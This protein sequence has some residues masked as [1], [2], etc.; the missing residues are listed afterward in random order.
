MH[1]QAQISEAA[2][3]AL[4]EFL[5]HNPH[6]I[7]AMFELANQ[8]LKSGQLDQSQREFLQITQLQPNNV[9]A[10]I[11]LGVVRIRQKKPAFAIA[12]FQQACKIDPTLPL[13]HRYLGMALMEHR[14][15]GDAIA[16]LQTAA[17]LEAGN[18]D[19]HMALGSA[20]YELGSF[21]DAAQAYACAIRKSPGHELAWINLGTCWALQHKF[22]KAEACFRIAIRVNSN[23]ETGH[24]LLGIAL[25]NLDQLE[26]AEIHLRRAIHLHPANPHAYIALAAVHEKRREY[27][28]A[29]LCFRQA[30][31]MDPSNAY[32]KFNLGTLHLR[33]GDWTRGF[34]LYEHRLELPGPNSWKPASPPWKGECLKGKTILVL[35]EQGIGDCLQF[36]RFATALRD[37]GATVIMSCRRALLPLLSNFDGVDR[38]VPIPLDGP[39]PAHDFHVW[40]HSIPRVLGVTKAEFQVHGPYIGI[41]SERV[42]LW[43]TRIGNGSSFK[44]GIIWR[45]NP[46]HLADRRRS[47][48]LEMFSGLKIDES[49]Q[50]YALQKQDVEEDIRRVASQ[51]S[52]I[53]FG[54]ELDADGAFLDTAAIMKVMD[55]VI[56]VDSA[57]AHLAGALGVPIWMLLSYNADWRWMHEIG[58]STWYP[59]MRIFRQSHRDDW[60]DVFRAMADELVRVRQSRI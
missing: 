56:S 30:I 16:P 8:L 45:G 26:A 40:L 51:C 58:Q 60:T 5:A 23:S 46:Q 15:F 43:K 9:S 10:W 21:R 38:W 4:R 22:R 48:P 3:G 19:N 31:E 25:D 54:K 6:H 33:R 47:V 52:V 28:Q 27:D 49:V 2:I 12:A 42:E 41:S 32:A 35:D 36:M 24:R 18:P 13:A 17:T 37:R 50:F 55:M 44:I 39:Q 14:Q 7:P 20:L 34:E 57:P 1:E 29:E 59:S 11:Q 53:H